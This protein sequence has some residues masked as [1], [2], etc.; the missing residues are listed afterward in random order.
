MLI[1]NVSLDG[2]LRDVRIVGDRVAEIGCALPS[3]PG[4][5]S[6][7]GLG[8]AILPGL[9][10]HHIHLNA[11]AAALKSVRC[12]PPEVSDLAALRARLCAAP[13]DGWVR[14]IGYHEAIG[15]V[16]RRWLDYNGPD[17]PV[18][19]QHRSGRMWI[20]NSAAMSALDLAE[21]RDGRLVDADVLL[22]TRLHQAPP[23][24]TD[25]G[26]MLARR[27]VTGVTEA[28]HRNNQEDYVR[29]ETADL[30]QR[31]LLMGGRTL[32]HLAPTAK[33]AVGPVKFHFHD[34]ALPAIDE[35]AAEI[36][37]AHAANR[38][39][40]AHCVTRAELAVYLAALEDAGPGP[41]DRIEHAGIVP[42]E[43]IQIIA[44]LGLTVVTQPHFLVERGDAYRRDVDAYDLPYLYP[45]AALRQA[46]IAVAA[47]SDAPFGGSDPWMAMAA[48]V[49][50]PPGFGM[51]E[52]VD[53]DAA[54]ALYTG[55]ADAPGGSP[56]A[57]RVGEIAD[58]CV[59]DRSW[60]A[61]RRD[62]AAVDVRLT[63]VG[64][65]SVYRSTASINPQRNAT[66][67]DIRRMDSAI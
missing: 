46:G 64:G 10:D 12:G 53:A 54:L 61:A 2:R 45:L 24:L 27:G 5:D 9:H 23:P 43:F 6:W 18:R 59:I 41:G 33:V 34:H 39:V 15:P 60:S 37:L 44:A 1:H 38:A 67:A 49:A 51:D 17:R 13:G 50:R 35:L 4:E 58:F 11:A 57:V 3:R 56:R 36:S 40:A 62:L 66:F 19:I 21:P 63:I 8:G 55:R 22:R 14:G 52:G 65:K 28:T 26:K 48:A 25:V 29:F 20:L 7:E 47:G 42:T 16:D 31:V 30:N 32:N